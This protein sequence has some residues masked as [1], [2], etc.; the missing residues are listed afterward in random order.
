MRRIASGL[1]PSSTR[2]GIDQAL[3]QIGGLGP[4]GAAIG[5]DRHRVG[6]HALD[7]DV[8]RRD[9]IEAGDEVCRAR[10]DEAAKRREIGAEIGDDGDAQAEEA[11]VLIERELGARDCGR[12]PDCRRRILPSGP[13]ATSP[14]AQACGCPDHQRLLGIDEGLHAE[15]RRRHWA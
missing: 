4:P 15:R 8:D 7:V 1:M 5:A 2:R 11:A 13:P 9:R 14:A 6:A 12:G 3:E 10:R